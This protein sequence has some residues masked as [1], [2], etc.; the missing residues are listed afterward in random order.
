MAAPPLG[1]V[2]VRHRLCGKSELSLRETCTYHSSALSAAAEY[3]SLVVTAVPQPKPPITPSF[4]SSLL[5]IF[6]KL[7]SSCHDITR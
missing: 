4:F 2:S 1:D 5:V 7:Y 3:Y 6:F